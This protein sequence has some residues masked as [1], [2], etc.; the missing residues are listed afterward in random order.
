MTI[1][2]G[3]RAANILGREIPV[4][5][6]DLLNSRNKTIVTKKNPGTGSIQV[7]EKIF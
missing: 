7:P 1:K 2:S 6:S 4:E 5:T 3:I